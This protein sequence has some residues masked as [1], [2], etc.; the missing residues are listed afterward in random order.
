[1]FLLKCQNLIW[2]IENET[3]KN[4]R[5]S[6]FYYSIC[7]GK[8][9]V[10]LIGKNLYINDRDSS[11]RSSLPI[12]LFYINPIHMRPSMVFVKKI[13]LLSPKLG[14]SNV[15][16]F[17]LSSI[18]KNVYWWFYFLMKDKVNKLETYLNKVDTRLIFRSLPTRLIIY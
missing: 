3:E 5:R 14:D 2:R 12:F 13:L 1:M 9:R 8:I 10:Y 6:G 7:M 18:K 16:V 11:S 4:D 15:Q 17:N